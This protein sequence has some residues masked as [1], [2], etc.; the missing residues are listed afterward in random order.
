[1]RHRECRD[2]E[3]RSGRELRDEQKDDD[4]DDDGG[5]NGMHERYRERA[6]VSLSVMKRRTAAGITG[7]ASM[8]ASSDIRG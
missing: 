2:D 8:K 6:R 5:E 1:M 7:V 3:H 4:E